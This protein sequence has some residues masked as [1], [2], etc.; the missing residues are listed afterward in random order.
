MQHVLAGSFL[1]QAVADELSQHRRAM[2]Y[3]RN[4]QD[5][6]AELVDLDIEVERI[7]AL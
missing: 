5:S 1:R 4:E 6:R 3:S 7:T 2:A